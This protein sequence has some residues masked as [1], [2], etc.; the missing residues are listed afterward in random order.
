MPVILC[1]RDGSLISYIL[2]YVD[3][4][5]LWSNEHRVSRQFRVVLECTLSLTFIEIHI[6]SS[7]A[8][9]TL[10]QLIDDPNPAIVKVV[11]QC[12]ATV[13]P[14]LFRLLY[15]RHFGRCVFESSP[16]VID[17]QTEAIPLHGTP[18]PIVKPAYSTWSGQ[19]LP[20]LVSS[21]LPSSS[22][23]ELFWFRRALCR[24]PGYYSLFHIC[25]K[26]MDP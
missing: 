24:I 5:C 16:V 13:Y 14:L 17:V 2:Q 26:L 19:V 18:C 10:A 3:P 23:S 11:V 21:S 8:L 12:L 15:V 25:R 4:L 9:D 7:Q 1:S 6:V 20:L 22:C